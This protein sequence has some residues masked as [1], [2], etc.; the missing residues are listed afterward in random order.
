M[1][2]AHEARDH[3]RARHGPG[4]EETA[5]A[6]AFA[7]RQRPS[8]KRFAYELRVNLSLESL[9]RQMIYKWENQQARVPASVLIAAA[10]ICG[11]S[12]DDLLIVSQRA[13]SAWRNSGAPRGGD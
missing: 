4:E 10:R 2:Q 5:R 11:L 9:S 8:I 13:E 12:V 3:R 1:A 7:R 6:I